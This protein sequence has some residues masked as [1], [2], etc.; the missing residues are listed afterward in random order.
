MPSGQSAWTL[1]SAFAI[2]M[3]S[4]SVLVGLLMAT[5]S[6]GNLRDRRKLPPKRAA[7][8]RT[9]VAAPRSP[10]AAQ[11][12]PGTV[13]QAVAIPDC[14]SLHPGYGALVQGATLPR[15]RA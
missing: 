4:V 15:W 14:A 2:S 7:V 9:I 11:R 12:N 6:S 5:A 1:S 3:S 13:S 10:D 8:E